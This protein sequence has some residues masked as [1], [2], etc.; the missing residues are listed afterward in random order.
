MEV[1]NILSLCNGNAPQSRRGNSIVCASFS[2]IR[3]VRTV[4]DKVQDN[5]KDKVGDKGGIKAELIHLNVTIGRNF[6]KNMLE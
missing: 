1:A 5:V 4:G 2:M 3:P 6:A